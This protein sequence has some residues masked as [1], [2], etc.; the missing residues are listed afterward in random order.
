MKPWALLHFGLGVLNTGLAC[1]H[2][3]REGYSLIQSA[4]VVGAIG[5]FGLAAVCQG[6][7]K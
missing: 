7:P 6:G 5:C 3:A 4:L 1:A 2:Y